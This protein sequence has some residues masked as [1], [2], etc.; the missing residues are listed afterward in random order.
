MGGG[1]MFHRKGIRLGFHF[2][3]GA[4]YF[5][6]DFPCIFCGR[7]SPNTPVMV[8]MAEAADR[9][10]PD[11][12]AWHMCPHCVLLDTDGLIEAALS[13]ERKHRDEL[14][15]RNMKADKR[16]TSE[17]YLDLWP[18]DYAHFASRLKRLGDVSKIINYDLAVLI[19]KHYTGKRIVKAA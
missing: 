11:S 17:D 16:K 2:L 8:E 10:R 4:E 18:E 13:M 12:S 14:K 9:E 7:K 1:A 6:D 19:A 3:S 5:G 15:R